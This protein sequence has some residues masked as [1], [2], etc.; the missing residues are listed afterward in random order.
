M[1][2]A[3]A[4]G[5]PR[6]KAKDTLRSLLLLSVA[7]TLVLLGTAELIVRSW[8]LD[9]PSVVAGGSGLGPGRLLR[10][11]P[12]LGWTLVPGAATTFG[13]SIRLNSLGL[14]SPEVGPKQ[15]NEFRVLSLGE[16][17]TFGIGVEAAET[18]SAQLQGLLAAR[19]APRPVTVVNAGISAYSSYQSLRYLELRGLALE[20]D[21][22]LFYH[23]ANDYMPSAVHD[24]ELNEVGVLL[25]DQQLYGSPSRRLANFLERHWGLYRF[26]AYSYAKHTIRGLEG[27]AL[28]NPILDIGLP[29]FDAGGRL[30]VA[31]E[32]LAAQGKVRAMPL[33]RR[34][35][36]PERRQNLEKLRALCAAR[37]IRLIVIHPSYRDSRRHECLLTRFCAERG[38]AMV[39]AHDAL[40]PEGMLSYE[41]FRDRWHPTALGHRRLAEALAAAIDPR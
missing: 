8:G 23:E 32:G 11:D 21:L 2:D 14:R 33:G 25:T 39:E 7:P 10:P 15:P 24:T 20:P 28:K 3:N 38:V 31:D 37:G 5:S 17:T 29:D 1:P 30:D 40:H 36:D 13:Q 6:R 34:V 26:V 27:A 16:S 9:R 41:L 12:D 22:V 18:Y 4:A 35:S 19:V